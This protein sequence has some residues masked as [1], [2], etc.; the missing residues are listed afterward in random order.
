[1]SLFAELKRRSFYQVAV[2]YARRLV[3]LSGWAID[4]DRAGVLVSP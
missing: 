4:L 1:M 3:A 2:V